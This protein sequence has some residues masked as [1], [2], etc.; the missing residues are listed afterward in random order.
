[1]ESLPFWTWFVSAACN[2]NR[3]VV[4]GL[5]LVLSLDPVSARA[6]E[7]SSQSQ[8]ARTE[9]WLSLSATLL[10]GGIAGS[11]ALKSAAL[12]D[13][14]ALLLPGGREIFDLQEDALGA[15]RLATGFGAAASLMALTSLLL[16]L[17]QPAGED[18]APD[19]TPV[20]NPVLS[21]NQLGVSCSGRF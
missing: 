11:F 7:H 16:L 3:W 20:I 12:E 17:Y 13:R 18:K 19:T 2:V 1:V 15:R 14:M 5:A 4:L 21:A 8:V 6:Q 10:L 9:L